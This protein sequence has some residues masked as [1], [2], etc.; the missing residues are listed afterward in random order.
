MPSAG[1][2]HRSDLKVLLCEYALGR[3]GGPRR[4][5]AP[6]SSAENGAP[7]P[8]VSASTDFPNDYG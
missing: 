6:R 4:H 7:A 3:R 1:R 5:R 8:L 2:A